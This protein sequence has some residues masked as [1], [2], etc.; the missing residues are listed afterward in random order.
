MIGFMFTCLLFG[1]SD[2]LVLEDKC[3][4]ETIC[5]ILKKSPYV[6][7]GRLKMLSKDRPNNIFTFLK[8]LIL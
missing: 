3:E 2:F 4:K 1:A 8:Y 5:T 7:L 6:Y